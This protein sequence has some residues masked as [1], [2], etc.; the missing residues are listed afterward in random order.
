MKDNVVVEEPKE[1]E[2]L[3][4]VLTIGSGTYPIFLQFSTKNST[5]LEERI[6]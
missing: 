6:R 5:S 2:K 4:L 3:S 1:A